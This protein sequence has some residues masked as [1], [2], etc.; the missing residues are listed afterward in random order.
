MFRFSRVKAN[1]KKLE[2]ENN[3]IFTDSNVSY[4]NNSRFTII[5]KSSNYNIFY[6]EII[7]LILDKIKQNESN[8]TIIIL[9]D[10]GVK[11][12]K[13]LPNILKIINSWPVNIDK[14]SS[15][16]IFNHNIKTDVHRIL[17]ELYNRVIC[18]EKYYG[19]IKNKFN[20]Y[21]QYS[22][23]LSQEPGKINNKFT[24]FGDN[25][26]SEYSSS[27]GDS[28]LLSLLAIDLLN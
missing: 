9:A 13:L 2:K 23:S 18:T 16:K 12:P 26:C 8:D 20:C 7:P 14:T 6:Q 21:L 19:L 10:M 3:I 1:F 11:N 24:F 28:I 27:N 22:V 4:L 15:I 25:M 17:D 5:D